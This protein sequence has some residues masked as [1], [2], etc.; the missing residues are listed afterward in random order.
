MAGC[1]FVNI[2]ISDNMAENGGGIQSESYSYITFDRLLLAD[3]QANTQG[4]GANIF[5]SDVDFINATI[6]N[7]MATQGGGLLYNVF[8]TY[9]CEITNSIVWNNIPDEIFTAFESP[10]VNYSNI[11]GGIEG[12]GNIS[13]DPMFVDPLNKDYHL[14]WSD[15]P[16]ENGGK[17]PCID[18]GDPKSIFDPDG[19]IADMGTYYYDQVMITS[20]NENNAFNELNIYPNPINNEV[21][22]SGTENIVKIQVVNLMGK[23]VFEKDTSGLQTET[24]DLSFLNSGIH[25]LNIYDRLG[26]VETKKIIKK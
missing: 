23:V 17:S 12:S 7:N 11:F 5:E 22:V 21:Q 6:T 3:N 8:S 10:M 9:E 19:T 2:T 13:E 16:L 14:Q 15:F 1:D 24:I 18:A 20:V 25:F 4:G 26:S